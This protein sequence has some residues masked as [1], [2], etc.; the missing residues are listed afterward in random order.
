MNIFNKLTRFGCIKTKQLL[1]LLLVFIILEFGHARP[2]LLI[3]ALSD[4]AR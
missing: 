1:I 4:A 3:Y 2:L